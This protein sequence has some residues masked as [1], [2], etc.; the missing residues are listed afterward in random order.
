MKKDSLCA[1]AAE[2]H[3]LNLRIVAEMLLIFLGH[4]DGFVF[5]FFRPADHMMHACN[6][7]ANTPYLRNTNWNLCL[8]LRMES[9]I[10][11]NCI[12][13]LS[14]AIISRFRAYMYVDV[15]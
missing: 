1:D 12:F 2:L 15:Q 13:F 7:S 10:D 5:L 6:R 14:R 8:G 9:A 3:D 11:R 4:S